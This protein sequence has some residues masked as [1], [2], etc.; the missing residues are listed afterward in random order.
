ME[1]FK[2]YKLNPEFCRT[3]L[4]AKLAFSF[5]RLLD[6]YPDDQFT[7]IESDAIKWFSRLSGGK[8]DGCDYA[9][10]H[11]LICHLLDDQFKLAHD[12]IAYGSRRDPQTNIG[13]LNYSVDDL[14]EDFPI[15]EYIY[16]LNDLPAGSLTL[17]KPSLTASKRSKEWINQ[18]LVLLE[19]AAPQAYKELKAIRPALLLASKSETS[20]VG[21]GGYS[22]SL[23]WG[24]IAISADKNNFAELIIQIIHELAHQILFA[25][26]ADVPLAY[27]HPDE[28]YSSPVRTDERPMDGLI[29]ACFVSARLH[30]VLGQIIS[31]SNF[32]EM[33]SANQLIIENARLGMIDI[34]ADSLATIKRFAQLSV[35]GERVM[36]ACSRTVG[37]R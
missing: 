18:G 7:T 8:V 13:V 17:T 2:I 35:L 20:T 22:T 34:V 10:H 3:E 16:S 11:Q 15:Y 21:F 29:H 23:A 12:V 6:T 28:R 27:N 14:G 31:S 24:T 30:E 1:T 33:P 9:L 36:N 19:N 32:D 5:K 4:Q 25:L 37:L 26:S